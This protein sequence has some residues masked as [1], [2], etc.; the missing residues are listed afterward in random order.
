ML[1]K[2]YC[3]FKLKKHHF[4]NKDRDKKNTK[5]KNLRLAL[6]NKLINSSIN[7][8]KINLQATIS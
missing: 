7:L 3:C 8:T 2:D 1:H 4:K 5:H 6:L